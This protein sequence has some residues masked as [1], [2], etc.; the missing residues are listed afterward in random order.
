KE[1]ETQNSVKPED[2]PTPCPKEEKPQTLW[3][4]PVL[5]PLTYFPWRAGAVLFLDPE[6]LRR[7]PV[8]AAHDGRATK[9]CQGQERTYPPTTPEEERRLSTRFSPQTGW[10]GGLPEHR[11]LER[12]EPVLGPL[13]RRPDVAGGG[14]RRRGVLEDV[15]LDQGVPERVGPG[16]QVGLLRGRLPLLPPDR[17]RGAVRLDADRERV[18]Q[19]GHLVRPGALPGAVDVL[20]EHV[21]D[22]RRRGEQAGD[23]LRQVVAGGRVR[24]SQAAQGEAPDLHDGARERPERAREVLG[25]GV[26]RV[27]R[28]RLEPQHRVLGQGLESVHAAPAVVVVQRRVAEVYR[29]EGVGEAPHEQLLELEAAAEG[30]AKVGREG[31]VVREAEE[32]LLVVGQEVVAVLVRGLGPRRGGDAA[33]HAPTDGA[34]EVGNAVAHDLVELP[35]ED[36]RGLLLLAGRPLQR[37]QQVAHVGVAPRESLPDDLEAPGHDVR[38]LDR[39]GDGEGHV[40]VADVVPLAAAYGRAGR[41]VHAALDDAAAALGAVLLHDGGDDHGRL[42]VVDDGVHDV[43]ARDGDEAVA[44]GLRHGCLFPDTARQGT[45]QKNKRPPPLTLLYP[46]EL[47]D[48][49]PELLPDPRVRPDAGD[50]RPGGP[51]A[52]GGEAD[53]PPL[54]EALDEHVPPE[55]AP[56]LPAE[57]GVHGYPNVVALDGPVHEGRAQGDVAGSHAES[58][59][60]APFSS[61][62]EIN[63]PNQNS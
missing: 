63:G 53:A 24:A 9:L 54:G 36:G 61:R 56:S 27:L 19:V 60:S 38:A 50:D 42:V 16:D 47:R 23:L 48:W 40:R 51:D 21:P 17:R 11:P 13:E 34:E 35:D 39:D 2:T 4:A 1:S 41:D 15:D 6:G 44:P 37:A 62:V 32:L 45:E 43:A 8:L 31:E 10:L 49:H 46:P 5:A 18:D 26:Q 7:G 12:G 29:A 52:P 25:R 58:L 14:L 55:A 28:L 22:L 20:L 57:D 3:T 33:S 30:E 59:V